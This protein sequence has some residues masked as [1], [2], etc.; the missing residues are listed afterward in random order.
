MI[1]ACSLALLLIAC[2]GKKEDAPPPSKSAPTPT[3]TTP[4]PK[5]ADKPTESKT[6]DK[7]PPP[8]GD[9]ASMKRCKEILTKSWQA[10][11][12]GFAKL[13]VA[14]DT[15]LE[16]AYTT[17]EYYLK[18]CAEL[19]AD[20]LDCLT[21]AENP[22]AGIDSCKVNEGAKQSLALYGVDK[23]IGLFE[24]KPIDKDA[25][26]KILAS[27]EGTWVSEWTFLKQKTTWTI[28]KAGAV[29]KAEVLKDG[30]PDD[31]A[32]VPDQLSIE[33]E[34]R[35]K[36]HWKDS[37][38]TQTLA[39]WKNGNELYASTNE[40]YDAYQIDD[41]KQFVVRFDWTY[42]AFDNGK[43]EAINAQGLIAPATCSFAQDKGNKVFRAEWQFPSDRG[44][45]KS[46]HVIVGKQFVHKSMYEISRFKKK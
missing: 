3:A 6:P 14:V 8:A 40:L 23:K 33:N 30:K 29:T 12:P 11:Q 27:L 17:N 19:P 25:A 18:T 9:N 41:Q 26:D 28:G 32:S 37:T 43:C 46:E 1:R 22:I 39:F 21:K 2:G 36:A 16:K 7:A 24:R 44:V 42:I 45:R 5:A 10:A 20:K 13:K 4:A 15:D 31:T 38:T 35:L 34:G